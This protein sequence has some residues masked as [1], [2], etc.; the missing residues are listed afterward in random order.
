MVRWMN[1]RVPGQNFVVVV[2]RVW[3]WRFRVSR[4]DARSKK[5]V[6]ARLARGQVLL[7]WFVHMGL[8]RL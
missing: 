7:E 5:G 6:V 4:E 3:A 8:G 2:L 1:E